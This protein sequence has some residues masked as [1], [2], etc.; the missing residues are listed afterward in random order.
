M[1]EIV[2]DGFALAA[3]MCKPTSLMCPEKCPF[4]GKDECPVDSCDQD[5]FNALGSAVV[6][7][8]KE[9]DELKTRLSALEDI[10]TAVEA[11]ID[12]GRP[13]EYNVEDLRAEL[14]RARKALGIIPVKEEI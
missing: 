6:E 9:R 7:A 1:S 2:T 4:Y 11:D 14:I 8:R 13:L 3:S 5:Q 12:S 10:A